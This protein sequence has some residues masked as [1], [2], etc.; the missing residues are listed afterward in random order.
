MNTTNGTNNA[1]STPQPG[2]IM[3]AWIARVW[4]CNCAAR[5]QNESKPSA[6]KRRLV[7]KE[8]TSDVASQTDSQPPA[9]H[10]AKSDWCM[11]DE[12]LLAAHHALV[13]DE[14]RF[15]VPD[16]PP[17]FRLDS[18]SVVE[19][20]DSDEGGDFYFYCA[21]REWLQIEEDRVA[22]AG[23]ALKR[24]RQA[25]PGVLTRSRSR[26][27]TRASSKACVRKARR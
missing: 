17:P 4:Q 20:T 23:R 24:H 19:A 11:Q 16:T 12:P 15:V 9:R 27:H 3:A 1:T 13:Q 25:T 5:E 10:D 7:F 8:E 18:D 6:C 14:Q 2:D 26:V 22:V 21:Y